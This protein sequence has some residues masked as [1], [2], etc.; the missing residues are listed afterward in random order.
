MP[1]GVPEPGQDFFDS[2]AIAVAASRRAGANSD[3]DLQI[4]VE[5]ELRPARVEDEGEPQAAS[6]IGARQPAWVQTKSSDIV[7]A[8]DLPTRFVATTGAARRSRA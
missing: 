8:A 7:I 5:L 4:A 3:I 1:G 2:P 6:A